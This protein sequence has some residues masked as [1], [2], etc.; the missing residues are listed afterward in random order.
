MVVN[1]LQLC[2]ITIVEVVSLTKAAE[3]LYLTQSTVSHR[4]KALEQEL[5]TILI[6]RKKGHQVISLTPK[7]EEFISIAERWLALWKDKCMLQ[8]TESRLSL[9]IGCVDSLN[10]YIF[11]TLYKQILNHEISIDLQVRT[12]QSGEIYNLL[13]TREIDVV[14][15]LRQI[16][17]KNIIIEPVLNERM[18]LIRRTAEDDFKQEFH[19]NELNSKNEF[20]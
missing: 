10:T 2:F 19:P 17:H 8:N 15:V 20:F 4:L 16:I 7:G 6:E 12:H 18:V 13:D 3:T 1:R 5:N 9:S 11:P 14:F